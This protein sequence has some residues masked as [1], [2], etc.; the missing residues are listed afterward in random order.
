M[1]KPFQARGAPGTHVNNFRLD[2][3][4]NK[5]RGCG[6]CDAI[7]PAS[8]FIRPRPVYGEQ[9]APPYLAAELFPVNARQAK[10][11]RRAGAMHHADWRYE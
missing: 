10:R 3:G 4:V 11:R 7:A 2:T 1:R 5:V 8:N 9:T 6:R